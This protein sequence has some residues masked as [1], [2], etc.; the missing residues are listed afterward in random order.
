M[1]NI[2]I[3]M[4][5]KNLV[6]SKQRQN[7]LSVSQIPSLRSFKSMKSQHKRNY[8]P[9]GAN[10]VILATDMRLNLKNLKLQLQ[11]PLRLVV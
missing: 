7:N 2:A 10:P 11:T 8:F 5:P 1:G 3:S 4:S 9:V 6:G